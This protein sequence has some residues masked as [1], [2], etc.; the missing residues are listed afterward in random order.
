MVS[1]ATRR[2]RCIWPSTTSCS[3]GS[4]LPEEDERRRRET[5]RE[6]GRKSANTPSRVSRVSRLLRSKEYLPRQRKLS[7]SGAST[8]RPVDHAGTQ[9]LEFRHRIVLPT[10]PTTRTGCS[11][12]A[13]ALKYTADPPRASVIC[14]NGS[15][16]RIEGDAAD[17]EEAHEVTSGRAREIPSRAEPI[18]QHDA[19]R[20][21]QRQARRLG[22][23]RLAQN[24]ALVVPGVGQTGEVFEVVGDPVRL[25]GPG[26]VATT[27]GKRREA[28]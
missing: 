10:T 21:G 17:N 1:Q 26:R 20:P 23:G 13:A 12:E 19:G 9:P 22:G 8:P 25:P 7:P 2:G 14:P 3:T 15:G 11:S 28:V 5:G 24:P 6:P 4:M 27:S 18:G 16:D